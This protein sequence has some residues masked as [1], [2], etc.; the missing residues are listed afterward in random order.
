MGSSVVT[1]KDT[2]SFYPQHNE[3][4]TLPYLSY[5]R[6]D[7][8]DSSKPEGEGSAVTAQHAMLVKVW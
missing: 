7:L 8:T 3:R 2:P 1:E 5:P 4:S 6:F